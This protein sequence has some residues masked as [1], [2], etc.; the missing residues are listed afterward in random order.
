MRDVISVVRNDSC[1]PDLDIKTRMIGFIVCFIIG[2]AITIL[3]FPFIAG[4]ITGNPTFAILYTL[5][6]ITSICS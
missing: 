6:N 2:I 1:C 4:G 3:S 5:G